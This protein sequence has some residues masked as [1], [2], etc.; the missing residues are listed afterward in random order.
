MGITPQTLHFLLE[1]PGKMGAL[2]LIV[3]KDAMKLGIPHM[4]GRGSVSLF[5][6]PTGRD[7]AVQVGDRILDCHEILLNTAI[8]S[9][10]AADYRKEYPNDALKV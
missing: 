8:I 1:L 4:R 5:A 2:L 7:E 10:W 6:F 3:F 9:R